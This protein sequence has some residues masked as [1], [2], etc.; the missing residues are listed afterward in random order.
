M[1]EQLEALALLLTGVLGLIAGYYGSNF[2]FKKKF[3]EFRGCVDAVDGAFKDNTLSP[4]ELRNIWNK[5]YTFFKN[6]GGG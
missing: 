5:C 2:F 4:E 6:I 1:V 3:S